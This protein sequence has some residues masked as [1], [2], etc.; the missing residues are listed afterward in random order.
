MLENQV[1]VSTED[2]T[3]KRLENIECKLTSQEDL[4]DTLNQQVY[5]QQQKLDEMERLCSAL[6]RRLKEVTSNTA[7]QSGLPHDRPPHY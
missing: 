1:D 6:A 2:Y 5:R 4:L 7:G 3:E